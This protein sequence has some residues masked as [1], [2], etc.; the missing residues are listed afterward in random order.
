MITGN[1]M[2]IT[3]GIYKLPLLVLLILLVSCSDKKQP[4]R[5]S[6]GRILKNGQFYDSMEAETG[7]VW[8]CTGKKSHAYHS[9]NEC[10]GIQSC[11]ASKKKISKDK[12]IAMGRTPCHYCHK[13]TNRKETSSP[14]SHLATFYVCTD[15]PYGYYHSDPMCYVLGDCKHEIEEVTYVD[16]EMTYR[17]SC[18][19]CIGVK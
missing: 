16:V 13:K 19:E 9:T 1:R 8:I 7:E 5:G 3:D 10:Y 12:A 18:P 2:K 4:Q 6:D 15:D 14:I 11:R 17:D